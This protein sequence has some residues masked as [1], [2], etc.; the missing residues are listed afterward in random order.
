MFEFVKDILGFPRPVIVLDYDEPNVI[1]S[2]D[3]ELDLGVVGVLAEIEGVKIKAQVQVLEIGI[4]QIR[5]E[6]LEPREALPLL[7]EV[8]STQEKRIDD[9]VFHKLSIRSPSIKGFRGHTLD[10]SSTGARIEGRGEFT[11]GDYLTITL[12]LTDQRTNFLTVTAEIC[13][14]AP[15]VLSGWRALGLRYVDLDPNTRPE[16]YARYCDF[17]RVATLHNS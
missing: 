5:A 9:R 13:W 16:D 12:D 14:I 6:W 11:P 17:L 15:S 1:L 7:A 3:S 10:L 2:C 4:D 8:F